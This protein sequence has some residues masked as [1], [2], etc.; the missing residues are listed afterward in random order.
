MPLVWQDGSKGTLAAAGK[1]LEYACHGPPPDKA[2]T[3][4]LLHEGLGSRDL[5][6]DT[7]QQLVNLTGC[8]VFVY[9]RAGYG[10]SDPVDLPRPLDYMTAEAT[11]TLPELLAQIDPEKSILLGHSDGATIAAIHAGTCPHKSLKAIILMAPHFFTEP[12]G[13]KA[14]AAAKTAFNSGDLKSRLGKHHVN[15]DV[16]FKGWNDAWLDLDFKNWNVA[17][18]LDTITVPVLAIQGEDD[19]YGTAAQIDEISTRQPGAQTH[20]IQNCKHSPHSEQAEITLKLISNFTRVH[21]WRPS[22]AYVPGQTPRHD[23]TLFD[24]LKSD[25]DLAWRIGLE[26]LEEGYFWEA[27]EVHEA[28]WLAAPQNS[29]EKEMVQ[30]VIQ[31][32]NAG[33]KQ[34]MNRSSAVKKLLKQ[35]EK[36]LVEALTRQMGPVMGLTR[37]RFEVMQYNALYGQNHKTSKKN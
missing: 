2:T 7:P 3:L 4:V 28:V 8:G 24:A 18:T 13:L 25:T 19:Q 32:A 26:F 10:A 1:I 16:T 37:N 27:H 11:V 6:R 30:A 22:H 21:T 29:A 5:W 15:V 12:N 36:H 23:E 33:L 35:A 9:S 20:L 31:L 17:D 34:R 14:I